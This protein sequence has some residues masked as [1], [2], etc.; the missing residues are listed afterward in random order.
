MSLFKRRRPPSESTIGALLV[1]GGFVTRDQLQAALSRKMEQG[2]GLLGEHLVALGALTQA[3]LD[4]LLVAQAQLRGVDVAQT[5]RNAV[6][7]ATASLEN[8]HG[9]LDA[10][11]SA[12]KGFG[13]RKK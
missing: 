6:A 9:S 13:E 11:E 10:L 8:L 3:Q 1:E 12:A 7:G 5:L 2:G 4:R